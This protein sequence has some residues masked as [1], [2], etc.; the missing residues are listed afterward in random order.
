MSSDASPTAT[1]SLLDGLTY[2]GAYTGLAVAVL[3]LYEALITFDREVACF[4]TVKKR[5][6]ATLL[7]YANKWISMTFYLLVFN[8]FA[9]F[10]SEKV[11]AVPCFKSRKLPS[12]C[13][14]RTLGSLLCSPCICVEQE[15]ASGSTRSRFVP[16]ASGR[17]PGP[18]WL[19]DLGNDTT[20][21][22]M[23][24]HRQHN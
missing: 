13:T 1:A 11:S 12:N 10:P 7:F 24:R 4:W 3:F 2:S 14:V 17:K 23:L 6:G 15:Q 20:V 16:G 19:S 5:S 22:G 9:P 18:L 8:N 21:L